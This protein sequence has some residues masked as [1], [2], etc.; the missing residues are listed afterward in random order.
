M[1][2]LLSPSLIVRSIH[3]PF[4]IMIPMV[5]S[6]TMF[7][8]IQKATSLDTPYNANCLIWPTSLHISK[9]YTSNPRNNLQ[10]ALPLLRPNHPHLKLQWILVQTPAILKQNFSVYMR[11]I[12][13]IMLWPIV[14]LFV[15]QEN[16]I[17]QIFER[18]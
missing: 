2:K 16:V 7:N 8:Q 14:T 17:F 5:R 4:G 18:S 13:H 15:S 1:R 11:L 6:N 10:E 9:C 3:F 12:N